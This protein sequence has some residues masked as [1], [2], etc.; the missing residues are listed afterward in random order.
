MNLRSRI[1][2]LTISMTI[3]CSQVLCQQVGSIQNPLQHTWVKTENG[4]IIAWHRGN[5]RD[6]DASRISI[7]DKQ[8]HP[9]LKFD[10][11]RIV[12]EAES[13]SIWDVSARPQQLIAVA[14]TYIKGQTASPG[15]VLLDFDFKGNLVSAVALEPSREIAAVALDDNLNAWTLTWG[16]GGK[17]A[18]SAPLVVEYGRTGEIVREVLT[19]NLFP[20]NEDVFHQNSRTGA[21]AAGY[22]SG[23]FWF[24]LPGSTDFVTI[25]TKDGAV[26]SRAQTG[27]PSLQDHSVWPLHLTREAS[28]SLIVQVRIDDQSPKPTSSL[29]FYAWSP[30]IKTWSP[31]SVDPCQGHRLIGVNGDEQIFVDFANTPSSICSYSRR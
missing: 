2:T 23:I 12:P 24:W 5:S 7:F 25:R 22:D 19:R 18:A 26:I 21:L 29:A 17:D 31:F 3:A 1:C 4:L 27:L 30:E 16:S 15:T 13:V 14:A 9:L 8:G 28:G 10:I 20:P 6:A 11:L